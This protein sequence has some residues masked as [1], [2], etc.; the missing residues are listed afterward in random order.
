MATNRVIGFKKQLRVETP[1]NQATLFLN[2][3]GVPQTRRIDF[4]DILE[5]MCVS[6]MLESDDVFY[7]GTTH[8]FISEFET[9]KPK[10]SPMPRRV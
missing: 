5:F 8:V 9:K 3:E 10:V 4:T 2:L 7:D 6:H 1:Q